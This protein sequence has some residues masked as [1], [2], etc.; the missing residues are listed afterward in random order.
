MPLARDWARAASSSAERRSASRSRLSWPVSRSAS[1][2]PAVAFAAG[3]AVRA[4]REHVDLALQAGVHVLVGAAPGVVGQL[5]DVGLPVGRGR[6][7]RRACEQCLQALLGR[8]IALVVEAV[9]L[10]RLHQVVDVGARSGHARVVGTLDH[11]RHD[12]GCEHAD[13]DQHDHQ[14]DQREAAL[15]GARER[16]VKRGHEG[17]RRDW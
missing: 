17:G 7:R 13:D 2:T 3:L 11:V 8:R 4:E 5:F 16:A 9:E 1:P 6:A 10:E 14:F 15:H 12:Q